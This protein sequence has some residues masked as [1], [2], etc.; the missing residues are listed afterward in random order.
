MY[1]LFSILSSFT[2]LSAVIPA[3]RSDEDRSKTAP[4]YSRHA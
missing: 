3:R 1:P 2:F 4:I